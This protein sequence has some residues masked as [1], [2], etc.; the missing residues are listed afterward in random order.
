MGGVPPHIKAQQD[1]ESRQWIV[2]GESILSI[3]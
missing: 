2:D 1:S 3:S